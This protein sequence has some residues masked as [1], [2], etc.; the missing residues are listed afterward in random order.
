MQIFL[1]I[2]L[3]PKKKKKRIL[4]VNFGQKANQSIAEPKAKTAKTFSQVH[5]FENFGMNVTH[6]V[7]AVV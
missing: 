5:I 7:L 4:T 6:G 1:K 2:H 3:K